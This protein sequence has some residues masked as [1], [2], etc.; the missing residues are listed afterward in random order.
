MVLA[1]KRADGIQPGFI[2]VPATQAGS[3]GYIACRSVERIVEML[4]EG[5]S[6]RHRYHATVLV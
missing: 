3:L 2:P 1:R 4:P 5:S 6:A